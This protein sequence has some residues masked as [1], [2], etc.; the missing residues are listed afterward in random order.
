MAAAHRMGDMNDLIDG[1]PMYNQDGYNHDGYNH[2]QHQ[3]EGDTPIRIVSDCSLDE[4]QKEKAK[5]GKLMDNIISCFHIYCRC[6]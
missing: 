1:L 6:R 2:M 5:L 4:L 3:Q